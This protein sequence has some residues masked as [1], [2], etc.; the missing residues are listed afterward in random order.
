MKKIL[1][2][3]CKQEISSFNPVPSR[4][5]DFRILRF[6]EL[7]TYHQHVGSEVGGALSVF[8]AREDVAFFPTYGAASNTSGGTL[9]GPDWARLA[10][11]FLEHLEA[12][13]AADGVYFSMHGAMGAEGELDP[14][15]YL[16]QEARRILGEEIPIVVS[17]DLHGILTDRMLRHSDAV[18]V[19]HTYPHVDFF[20]TGARAARVLLR[21]LD[22][23]ARPV[24][25]RVKVPALVRGD[26][27]I[28][29]TGLIRHVV[30]AAKRLEASEGVLSAGMFW[31][32]PFTD[33]P[34]LRSNAVVVTDG[35]PERASREA[36]AMAETFW[37]HHEAMQVPLNSLEE[38]VRLAKEVRGTAIMVDAADATSSGASGD[39]NSILR[40]LVEAEYRGTALIPIVDPAA[41]ES[42]FAAGV[43]GTVETTVGGTLDPARFTPLRIKGR[44]RGLFD[45]DLRSESFG[46]HWV[47]GN[48]AVVQYENY[49]LVLTS[50][51]V[52]L[53]D[54]T[55]FYAAGQNPKWFDL[56]VVKSPHCQHHMFE[57]WAGRMIH[58]DAPGAT[59]ANV[60]RLGHTICERPIFPLDPDIPF[61]PQADLFVRNA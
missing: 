30:Q 60:K 52:H 9:A 22:A 25:A 17:L 42:A 41:V 34:E 47:S 55:L 37:E 1:I 4:Y 40:A 5:E 50:R 29:E 2:A 35:D 19:Y 33:V 56:V 26:E 48:S 54:R 51:P 59:S 16:L 8:G 24:T 21:I 15:G 44:V 45:G 13:P 14:E 11:E 57:E 38:S 20:E 6:G 7:V 58:V 43:G 18:V 27:L 3:E 23:G 31:G 39:S 12:A 28:T 53:F 10:G 36:I 46:G 61:S 32:N 49:T